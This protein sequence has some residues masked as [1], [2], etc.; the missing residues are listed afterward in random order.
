LIKPRLSEV[1]GR[2]AGDSWRCCAVSADR[3]ARRDPMTS[4]ARGQPRPAVLLE[5][6]R[7]PSNGVAVVQLKLNTAEPH[8]EA[9]TEIVW[10]SLAQTSQR[11]RRNSEQVGDIDREA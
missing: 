6:Q 4:G 5:V 8:G 11:C 2:D 1:R 10:I 9:R 7:D 3:G